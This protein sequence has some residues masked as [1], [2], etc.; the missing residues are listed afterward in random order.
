[1]RQFRTDLIYET[2]VDRG[3][4]ALSGI[5]SKDITYSGLKVNRIE[6][7]S[8]QAAQKT[9]K[10]QGKYVTV[11]CPKL[12]DADGRELIDMT[13]CIKEQIEYLVPL[14]N[15]TVLVAGLGNNG[16]T[17]D[18]LGPL[19]VGN[20]IVSRHI[21][22]NMQDVFDSLSLGEV[23]AIAPGVL[24]Q[25][26]VESADIIKA[27]AEKIK[28]DVIIAIDSLMAGKISR[29]AKT[30]Q[31]SNAGI[32]PGSGIGNHRFEI[33]SQT[34][35]IPVISIGIPMVIEASTLAFD[36]IDDDGRVNEMLAPFEE[37]LVVT[38]KFV[39][40]IVEKAARVLGYSVN[41]AFHK[42]M[43]VEDMASLLA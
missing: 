21:K 19:A 22:Q 29:L 23:S 13:E 14:E 36:L 3:N 28:P 26:G 38:P 20:I 33:S 1:M 8:E 37:D 39:D 11:F 27:V 4:S 34:M 16:I 42:G 32:T 6:V 15:K 43:T 9:G 25:T 24:G 12:G 17:P 35:G 7:L 10:K 31:L 18:A 30:V 40:T 2:V 5:T 41:K